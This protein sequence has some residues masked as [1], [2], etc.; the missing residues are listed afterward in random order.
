MKSK[1]LAICIAGMLG[2]SFFVGMTA[3]ADDTEPIILID[4][5]IRIN[6]DSC[7]SDIAS[8][9]DGS[10]GNPWIIEN[11]VINGSGHGN[12][13]YI[14]NTTDYIT[15]RNCILEWADSGV[16]NYWYNA[17]IQ[18]TNTN[19]ITLFN[20]TM[21]YNVVGIYLWN[22]NYTQIETNYIYYCTESGIGI[23]D[24]SNNVCY[25][26][27]I[28]NST[29]GIVTFSTTGG[30][31][32]P[33]LYNTITENHIADNQWEGILLD[34]VTQNT[35]YDNV[36]T[37]NAYG[38]SMNITHYNNITANHISL[39]SDG[40]KV[41]DSEYNNITYN[42]VND[43]SHKGITLITSDYNY[44]S[45]N[46]ATSNGE[47][48]IS[49][50]NSC[51][52]TIIYNT[53]IT[54]QYGLLLE[55]TSE[56]NIIYGN[57]MINNTVEQACDECN[58]NTWSVSYPTGGNFYSDYSSYD[59]YSGAG[60]DVAGADGIGDE[61]YAISGGSA[62]DYY[63]LNLYPLV[64]V[65]PTPNNNTNNTNLTAIGDIIFDMIPVIVIILFVVMIVTGVNKIYNRKR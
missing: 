18:L 21:N 40:I 31:V 24:S 1:L 44:I 11:K 28:I 45:D 5:E 39:N 8:S 6:A 49:L 58:N 27:E 42:I 61:S 53:L 30:W 14:G 29:I 3:K 46:S 35:V 17:G 37:N 16:G 65:P 48:G 19:N 34:A 23:E 4:S 13:I 51:L 32:N 26:N 47:T 63:P 12:C 50:E 38:I 59:N 55:S 36:L 2:I 22:A 25:D 57:S 52:N 15:V 9:G 33:S 10:L 62:V 56:E 64:V 54:N 7:I 43:N 60:Q 20:N 41:L